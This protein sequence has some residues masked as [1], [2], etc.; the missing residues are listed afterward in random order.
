VA[1]RRLAQIVVMLGG[2]LAW[3]VQFTVIYGATSV[4]CALESA[5]QTLLGFRLIP[6]V[7]ALATL[8]ALIGTAGNLALAVAQ[9]RRLSTEP[10]SETD[11][12][13]SYSAILISS[14]S[15]V[16]IAWHGLPAFILPSCS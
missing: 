4:S 15:L 13:L 12:F 2:L 8:A 11:M 10:S 7:I 6:A 16:A 1:A 9:Y 5:D 14:F 3:A